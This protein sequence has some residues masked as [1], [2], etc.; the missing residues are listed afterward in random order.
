ML[1]TKIETMSK[2]QLMRVHEASLEV[3]ERTGVVFEDEE[4][5]IE[6]NINRINAE[7]I[8]AEILGDPVKLLDWLKKNE[9]PVDE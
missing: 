9:N 1:A 5:L 3:M 4:A 8:P 2:D 6:F 7:K